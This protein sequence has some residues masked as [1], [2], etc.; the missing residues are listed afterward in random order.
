MWPLLL[1]MNASAA[2]YA[3]RATPDVHFTIAVHCGSL[4][5]RAGTDPSVRLSGEF[6]DAQPTFEG[7]DKE[8]RFVVPVGDALEVVPGRGRVRHRDR[9]HHARGRESR[10]E[11]DQRRRSP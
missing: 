1:S 9:R 6:G 10:R 4:T 11:L 3:H 7:S 8:L 5:F 2:D